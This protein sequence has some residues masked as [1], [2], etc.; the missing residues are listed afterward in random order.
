MDRRQF[1]HFMTR[2]LWGAVI[3][4]PA[5]AMAQPVTP[6]S[7]AGELMKAHQYNDAIKVLAEATIGK[8]DDAVATENLMLGECYYLGGEYEKGRPF[9]VKA[10]HSLPD[11]NEKVIAEYRLACTAYRMKYYEG[12]VDKIDAFANGHPNDAR[13]GKLLVFKMA[14]VAARGKDAQKDLEALHT[15]IYADIRRYDSATGMEADQILCEFYRST[16]QEE[17]AQG[18]YTRLVLNFRKAIAD[19][20]D[21]GQP[22]P[23]AFEK[24]HD[25]A[26]LQ[27]GILCLERK[28]AAEATKWLENVQYD[29]EAK[30]RSRLLL[31]KI[32]FDRQDWPAVTAALVDNGLVD[33]VPEGPLKSDMYL[34][35][36]LCEKIR[37]GGNAGKA[38]EYLRKVGV[39]SRGFAQAQLAL[40]DAYKE[41]GLKDKAIAGYRNAAVSSEL[42]PGALASLATIYMDQA[43]SATEPAKADA[44]NRQAAEALGELL[45]KYPLSAQAKAAQPQVALLA[46]D[47]IP[48][49]SG[50][51]G[52]DLLNGWKALARDRAGSLEA[53]EAL[54]SLGRHYFKQVADAKTGKLVKAPDYAGCAAACDQLLD[55]HRYSGA[56]MAPASW[57]S[58]RGEMLYM[59]AVGELASAY[60]AKS[61]GG[62]AV[63][64]YVSGASAARA[65]EFFKQARQLIDPKQVEQIRGIDLGLL[66]AMFKSSSEAD[67]A[68]VERRFAE[69]EADCGN[70][71]RFQ[72]L[73]MDLG[74]WYEEQH[75]YA[76]AAKVYVGIADRG[77]E[78]PEDD[79][80]R[81]LYRG[82]TLYSRAA[83]DAQHNAAKAQYCVYI[84]PRETINL[85]D[86]LLKTYQPFL[87]VIDI[88]WPKGG[89]GITAGE[90][91]AALSKASGIP[92]V[93]SQQRGANTIA[94][95]L[96]E[97]KLELKDGKMNTGAALALIFDRQWHRFVEDIGL[98]DGKATLEPA[99][100][101]DPDAAPAPAIEIY[102]VRQAQGR[103]APLARSFGPWGKLSRGRGA[104][105]VLMYGII[106]RVE[107]VAATKVLWA[108]GIDKEEK[109]GVEF[110]S[111]PE[112]P[113]DRDVTCAQIL[114]SALDAQ[115]LRYKI[116]RRDAAT[117]LYELAKDAFNKLRKTQSDPHG[118]YGERA[119]LEV[120]MNCYNQREYGK[121]KLVLKEYLKVFD[122]PGSEFH[123]QACFWVGWA[124]ENERKYK[125]A[126]DYYAR[127]AAERL[128]I[129]KTPAA[130][131]TTRRTLQGELSYDT[132]FALAEPIGGQIKNLSVA[133]FAD[134]IQINTHVEVQVDPAAGVDAVVLNREPFKNVPGF[135]VL[136]DGLE[137]AG[138]T[139]RV[140]SLNPEWAQKA[141][142]RLALT[143]RKDNL[144]DQALEACN[145]LLDRFPDT[146]KRR[147]VKKLMLDIYK[148]LHDYRRVLETLD[149][150][151]KTATDAVEQRDLNSEIASIY[152]DMADYDSAVTAYADGL[153]NAPD[154]R[155]KRSL[156]D[157]YARA[158]VR[159]GKFDDA[160]GQYKVLVAEDTAPLAAFTDTLLLFYVNFHRGKA[161]ERELP[162]DARRFIV[163]YEQLTEEQRNRLVVDDRAK[164]MVIYYVMAL[165]DVDKER[166]DEAAQ[167]FLAA[168]TSPDD[169]VSADAAYR[170][171]LLRMK[172]GQY[173]RARET[174]EYLLFQTRSNEAT[175]RATYSLALCLL[176]LGKTAQALE[177]FDQLI[178]RYPASP[179][180]EQIK[181]NPAYRD[182]PAT[183]PAQQ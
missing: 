45:T 167:K 97:K 70:D 180:V 105:T 156:R 27:L 22:V 109:L 26:A 144:M 74:Q 61:D 11:G 115:Q 112:V 89:Q 40:A 34:L 84:Y 98:T 152:F 100:R 64:V 66:E 130:G 56:G 147:D 127:A 116:I 4:W 39:D 9:Y 30:T 121:M 38:E 85:G 10:F 75:R 36:G 154:D 76:D 111:L 183:R 163:K 159:A 52:E 171:G 132:L 79:V 143:Y 169:V 78:L 69:L 15:K 68:A 108:D 88:K 91:L 12:A 1:R 7:R 32:A 90:A 58:L 168:S 113:P 55:E 120:A 31:A 35:L 125:E 179:Y 140:Q 129:C 6:K 92:F 96:A 21:S 107:E 13:V 142:Y 23:V 151:K 135:D 173:D 153:D 176:E 145:M 106:Q 161:A 51:A 49:G 148:G 136:C 5:M 46:R 67:S 177:R 82:G 44:L 3:L 174:F 172:G 119:L 94:N 118:K 65:V 83:Y 160:A 17:K 166:W 81:L 170:L 47:G 87:D 131:P 103:L 8:E 24:A 29:Q 2:W 124:F 57:K 133:Q 99:K 128:V 73:A 25:N 123:Q 93:W 137:S 114:S 37:P 28:Q 62:Q 14:I 181:K 102:D 42:A 138:L 164:A 157:P 77:R 134:F 117:G 182:R 141:Y 18:V 126:T 175:V 48:V 60:P 33:T 95:Y 146:D 104:P 71:P 19:L 139:F 43:E 16:S 162:E 155:E 41:H 150:L 122:R 178:Q 53:A 110:R 80:L 86:D 158:L 165:V 63:P 101:D 149:E 59:R 72:K 20:H 54:A 50:S